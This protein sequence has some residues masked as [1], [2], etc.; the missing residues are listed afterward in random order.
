VDI[1]EA[2]FRWMHIF[3]GIIWIGM[4]YFFNWVNGSFVATLDADTKKKVVPELMPRALFWFRWGAA[5]T[6]ITGFVLLLLVFYHGGIMF[7]GGRGWGGGAIGMVVATFLVVFVYD[8]LHGSVKDP[9]TFAIIAFA[10]TAIMVALMVFVG[11]FSYRA[12]NIHLGAMFGTMMAFN[13]WFRIWPAQQ[14]IITAIKQGEAPDAALVALAGSRSKHNTYMSLPLVWAM[15]NQHTTAFAGGNFG[16]P[17]QYSFVVL[18]AV[19]L[20]GWH[21]VWQCYRKGGRVKGF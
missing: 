15:I 5:W 13:V 8:L 1:L 20:L 6:W 17:S 12:F 14:K 3:A 21:I 4:L 7:D 11:Q 19:V 18:L 10:G 2:V 16:I 9:K